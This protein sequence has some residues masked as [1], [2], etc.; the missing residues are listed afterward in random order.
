M[1][2]GFFRIVLILTLCMVMAVPVLAAPPNFIPEITIEIPGVPDLTATFTDVLEFYYEGTLTEEIDNDNPIGLHTGDNIY[3]FVFDNRTESPSVGVGPDGTIT[4]PPPTVYDGGTA[5]FNMDVRIWVSGNSASPSSAPTEEEIQQRMEGRILE[6]GEIL[7]SSDEF[8]FKCIN[9]NGDTIWVALIFYP[10]NDLVDELPEFNLIAASIST[11]AVEPSPA[12]KQP[13]SLA[14]EA[15][16]KLY[17]LGLFRG[18]GDNADGTPNFALDRAPTRAEAI[19]MF[20]RLLG[21]DDEAQ[22]GTWKT[23]FTDVSDWAQ[24][25]VGYAYANGLTQGVGDTL[26]G[27]GNPATASM[28]LTF[29]LR[30]L[31]YSS[32]DDFAW[33]AA[34]ELSDELGFTSGEYNSTSN[35]TRGNAA[36]VSFDA[37]S[38]V[39]KETG[40]AL[41]EI[42]IESGAI[43]REAAESVGLGV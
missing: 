10:E 5:T 38:A 34:W 20:V 26:F 6:K 19:T 30:A 24:P 31:G 18:V 11:L 25:Y 12:P 9:K 8:F 35:F 4:L 7:G 42:L 36:I 33:N 14:E 29:V 3:C 22:N 32:D 28:Y 40:K 27:T 39:D 21:K 43:T 13:P 23:P 2:R 15:A 1:K 41:F 16:D 17:T 37:L